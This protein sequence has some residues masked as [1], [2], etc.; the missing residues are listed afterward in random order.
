MILFSGKFGVDSGAKRDLEIGQHY[1]HQ[2]GD[3]TFFLVGCCLMLDGGKQS[4]VMSHMHDVREMKG[5]KVCFDFG[6][7]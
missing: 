1:A 3:G 2:G 4:D 5:V 6:G 7:F